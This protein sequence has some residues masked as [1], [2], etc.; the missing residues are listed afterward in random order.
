MANLTLRPLLRAGLPR[1]L[2]LSC[3]IISTARQFSVLNR[4]PPNYPGHI[5]LTKVEKLGL[6]FGSAIGSLIDPRRGGTHT[7]LPLPILS[8]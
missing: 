7:H 8:L 3:T 5:P 6:A 4:P 2:L 1:E